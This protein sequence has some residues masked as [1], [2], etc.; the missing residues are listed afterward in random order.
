VI[1][2]DEKMM[3]IL[4]CNNVKEGIKL[5]AVPLNYHEEGRTKDEIYS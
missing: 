3:K 4:T 5:K 2:H 1:N